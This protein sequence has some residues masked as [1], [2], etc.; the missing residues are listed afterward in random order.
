MS[1]FGQ[2]FSLIKDSM[3]YLLSSTKS[4]KIDLKMLIIRIITKRMEVLITVPENE[5]GLYVKQCALGALE[6]RADDSFLSKK[7]DESLSNLKLMRVKNNQELH[8]SD[9]LSS[10]KLSD[11]EEFLLT[12]RREYVNYEEFDALKFRGPTW[13]D[14][15]LRTSHL[16]PI[17]HKPIFRIGWFFMHDDMRK[18]VISLAQECAYL[19]APTVYADKMIKYYRQRITNYVK[20]HDDVSAVLCQLGFSSDH[21]EFA[22]KL[23]ANN[24]RLAL[25]W[26]IDNVK[27]P[28]QPS[29]TSSPR[30]SLIS[31]NRRG[32]I[33]SS[34]FE[35]AQTIN[36]RVD[37]LLEIVSFY[38]EKDEPVYEG[39]IKSMIWM[40][41]DIDD[42]R[43]AL[44]MTRNNV[45]AA[46]AYLLGDNNPSI[47]ELRNGMSHSSEVYKA[48]MAEPN[49]QI[50]LATA[51][52]FL[53]LVGIL[54]NPSQ[55]MGYDIFSSHGELMHHLVHLYHEEKHCVTVNQFN[56]SHIPISALSAPNV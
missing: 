27:N 20:H 26:L 52:S 48:V 47:L 37:G 12:M 28:E 25:D 29:T 17:S 42:A 7:F 11:N 56:N 46:C 35:S 50:H 54:K 13:N 5:N 16:P 1:S 44:R 40:G 53:F 45:G 49:I 21:V 41:F 6:E 3:T 55:A 38:A 31:S 32:S 51:R 19:L 23:N 30:T 8:D 33:L 2:F 14:V 15:L 9:I 39:H 34:S 43:E 36:E 4:S 10:L 24:Y 18:V 22:L